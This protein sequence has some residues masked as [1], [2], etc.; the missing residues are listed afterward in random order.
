MI[1]S[2]RKILKRHFD[3]KKRIFT[4][5]NLIYMKDL[6]DMLSR[7]NDFAMKMPEQRRLILLS[8]KKDYPT[9][10]KKLNLSRMVENQLY[11]APHLMNI[12]IRILYS[13]FSFIHSFA[14]SSS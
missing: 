1:L 6:N 10:T 13:C 8:R 5:K 14:F 4:G 12:L 2:G 11:R 9:G 3:C 7:L